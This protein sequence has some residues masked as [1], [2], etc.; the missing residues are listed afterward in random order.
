MRSA[1][2]ESSNSL[3]LQ[4][5]LSKAISKSPG[6]G[7]RIVSKGAC[8]RILGFMSSYTANVEHGKEQC[9][10][11]SCIELLKSNIK[12]HTIPPLLEGPCPG[13]TPTPGN[14]L[15]KP[16]VLGSVPC[17]IP[18]AGEGEGGH[19]FLDQS[20]TYFVYLFRYCLYFLHVFDII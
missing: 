8:W 5:V 13:C 9:A 2:T 11:N 19:F 6:P 16:F 7:C 18:G 15:L 12:F 14:K 20:F 3:Y 17:V 4:R 1:E 10:G